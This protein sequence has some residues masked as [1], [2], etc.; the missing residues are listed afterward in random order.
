MIYIYDVETAPNFF[1]VV[2]MQYKGDDGMVFEISNRVNQ[3]KELD[4]FLKENPTLIGYNNHSYD[5]P[6]I[7]VGPG[8]YPPPNLKNHH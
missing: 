4:D 8:P 1:S 3:S 5:D 7:V 2:L 6:M